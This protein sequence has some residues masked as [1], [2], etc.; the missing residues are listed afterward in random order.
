M[1]KIGIL[2]IVSAII[3]A[4]CGYYQIHNEKYD[5]VRREYIA[6][7]Y[8]DQELGNLYSPY[9]LAGMVNRGIAS[10]FKKSANAWA[11]KVQAYENKAK[12]LYIS[13]GVL[14][15]SG[16][17]AILVSKKKGTMQ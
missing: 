13:G 8:V 1:R 16:I 14:L 15:I 9:S 6:Y 10:E 17:V 4:G 5:Q 3:C 12:V 11:P 7:S 2:M